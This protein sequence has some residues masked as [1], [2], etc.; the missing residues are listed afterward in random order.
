MYI[1]SVPNRNSPPAILLRESYRDAD[2]IK[3]RTIANLS[4]WPTE[5]VEGLRTLLKGGKVAPADQES[6]IVRRALPHGHVAAVLGTLRNI[7]LDRM[8]GPPRNRCRDLVIAMIVARLIAPASK[9]ATARM[10]DPLTASSSLG[11]V[12]GL[13]PV[14]EDELYVALDWLGER[15]EAIE[16]ALARKHLHDGTLVLYDVSSSYVE[17][18]CCELARLGYNRDGKKGKLQIAY[19][20]L[21]AADGCPVAIEVFEGDTGD[22]RTL[23]AQIDKVKKRF[24]LERVALVGDRG[25]I[26]QARL[27]AEIAPAGLDWITALRAPAIRTLVEAGALQMSL[28]DQ[29]DMA[30]ITSPDYPGERLIVCRN[31]DLARERTRKREDL[32]AATEADLA[33]I[34]AAV[35]RARNPLRG[36]AEIALKVGAVVNRHKVA[37]HFELSIGE[38]S[39]SFHRKTE[40]IAAEAALDGIY[41]VRTNLPK[42]LL[43]D[44]AT[45]GAYKSLAR[46]ERAFRSLKTVDIHLRPIFHWTTPRVRAHVLLCM[47]AYHVEHHMRARLAPMLYDETDHE[48]AAA[49]RF[50]RCQGRALRSRQAQA[51]H[52]PHRRRPA[53]AQL[54]KPARRPRHLCEDPGDHRAQRQIRLQA[55]H[56][57][58]SDPAARLRAPRPQPGSYPVKRPALATNS[59]ELIALSIRKKEV[60]TS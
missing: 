6:I 20:L 54:P 33:V 23:A 3:K 21:C 26:T 4:D 47:L 60:R 48:A 51:D 57:A 25:M 58:N 41:V 28:F 9:L 2:K 17:G 8:L 29:R 42:K 14:D 5:I 59:S 30:A 32:L 1:E 12:L 50:H 13:G 18:R 56:Q 19:G 10:L 44:A 22:P 31:P 45:V 35:R 34:A 38:A 7:G 24:A 39:F 15:Q 53:G 52:R 37:K 49:M 11:E 27:D 40:A 16:K 36:E 43:D 46:V 55:P